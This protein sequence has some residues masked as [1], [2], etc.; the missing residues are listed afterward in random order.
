M[1]FEDAL[2]LFTSHLKQR[3]LPG[4]LRW[5]LRENFVMLRRTDQRVLL[6]R[7]LSM[8]S[9]AEIQRVYEAALSEERKPAPI[10]MGVLAFDQRG[11][12][13]TLLGDD[14]DCDEENGDVRLGEHRLFF[15]LHPLFDEMTEPDGP[16]GTG[17]TL[18]SSESV[19][20]LD[21]V[22]MRVENW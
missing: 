8:V 15:I 12:V 16:A 3:G 6:V 18:E 2:A 19:G 7:N 5:G 14:Y 22:F 9:A 13:A 20:P 1:K 4:P 17:V 10:G 11:S 21:Y